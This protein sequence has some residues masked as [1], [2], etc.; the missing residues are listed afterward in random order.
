MKKNSIK[1][2][3]YEEFHQSSTLQKKV[4]DRD[5]YTYFNVV[6]AFEIASDNKK[7]LDILDFGCGVGTT[8]TYFAQLGHRVVGVD[9]SEKSIFIAKKNSKNAGV[10]SLCKFGILGKSYKLQSDQKKY[11]LICLFEVVEHLPDDV[12]L[13]KV[14][15]KK[16]KKGGVMLV[17]TR[18][19]NSLI[20]KLGLVNDFEI[21]VG[22]VRRYTDE[23]IQELFKKIRLKVTFNTKV[24]SLIRDCLYCFKP[25][26]ILVKLIRGPVATLAMMAETPLISLF[27]NSGYIIIAK[28]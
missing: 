16:L 24:D 12:G 1:T 20:Y 3:L 26:G 27:G 13:L 8:S 9:V 19:V 21:R 15:E 4:M 14:L 18:S 10:E 5:N 23:S 25:L 6:R 22:H 11:D 17:T 7:E 28:K 2:E